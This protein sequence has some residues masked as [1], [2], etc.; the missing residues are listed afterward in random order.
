MSE[1]YRST[2]RPLYVFKFDEATGE[3]KRFV[4]KNYREI[5]LNSHKVEYVF[6]SKEI[7]K[8]Q[9][10][11]AIR[12]DKLD[13][14]VNNKVVTFHDDY[15]MAYKI[16]EDTIHEKINDYQRKVKHQTCILKR[17]MMNGRS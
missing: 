7:N 17:L 6:Q 14:F 13:R 9:S 4:V 1:V 11:F 5:T 15:E 8:E 3:V 10:Y 2:Q 12:N 16:I